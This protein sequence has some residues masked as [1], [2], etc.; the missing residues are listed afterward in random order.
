MKLHNISKCYLDSSFVIALLIPTHTYSK[1]ALVVAEILVKKD[2]DL[3]MS[4]L[5]IDEVV[6]V[7]HKKYKMTLSLIIRCLRELLL[8][9]GVGM[10]GI[11]HDVNV[12]L[13]YLKMLE[14][15]NL[16]PRDT[17]HAHLMKNNGISRIAS[18]DS[19]FIKNHKKLGIRVV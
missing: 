17:M 9:I 18:F 6:Y 4:F 19:D 3:Y 2:M 5:V 12:V 13:D 1:K 7:L 10:I 15:F 11:E 8:N 14:K 16:E